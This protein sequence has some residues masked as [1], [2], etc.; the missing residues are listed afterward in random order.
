[1]SQVAAMDTLGLPIDTDVC[2]STAQN[3]FSKRVMKRQTK[4]LRPLVPLLRQFL[5]PDETILL[6]TRGS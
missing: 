4:I 6:A 3:K 2:F 5:E 1:M